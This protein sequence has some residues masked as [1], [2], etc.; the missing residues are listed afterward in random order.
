MKKIL[1]IAAIIMLIP[2]YAFGMEMISDEAMNDVTGQAGVSIATDISMNIHFDTM[3]W[4]DADGVGADDTDTGDAG[5]IGINDFDLTNLTIR[6]RPELA[7]TPDQIQL[8]TIDV[9]TDATYTDGGTNLTYVHMLLGTQQITF[10]SMDGVVALGDTTT[11]DQV[12]GTFYMGGFILRMNQNSYVDIAARA[13]GSG[14]TLGF[15]VKIAN[16]HMDAM[17]WG[18]T[19]GLGAAVVSNGVPSATHPPLQAADVTSAGYIGLA[20]M[21]IINLNINGKM[22]I[23]VATLDAGVVATTPGAALLGVYGS[24]LNAGYDGSRTAVLLQFQNLNIT[25]GSFDADL[26]LDS[27]ANLAASGANHTLGSLYASGMNVT[28][29]GW[30]GIMAH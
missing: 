26:R 15:G 30:V 12:M 9:A 4:G 1:A 29:N 25:M 3:A 19:D 18:D 7:A 13:T 21:D 27:A 20:D 5:W 14:V 11:L 8:F 28:V 24:M 2:F 17:S 23:D 6:L 16:I 10:D 22:L